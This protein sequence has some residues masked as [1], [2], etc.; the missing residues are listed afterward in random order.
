[1]KSRIVLPREH[2]RLDLIE[3]L[4]LKLQRTK[5]FSFRSKSVLVER[6]KN[7]LSYKVFGEIK[8]EVIGKRFLVEV[9]IISELGY[10]TYI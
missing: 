3:N 6:V 2:K 5:F 9:K 10:L 7:K 1:M 4:S 8:D